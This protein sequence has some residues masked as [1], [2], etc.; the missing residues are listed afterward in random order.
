MRVDSANTQHHSDALFNLSGGRQADH[1][2][3]LTGWPQ[4]AYIVNLYALTFAGAKVPQ[5]VLDKAQKCKEEGGA[6]SINKLMSDLPEL[7]NRNREILNVV[8]L[9]F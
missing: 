2:W 9:A 7:L 6:D 5:S 1:S 3:I 4:Y 8:C